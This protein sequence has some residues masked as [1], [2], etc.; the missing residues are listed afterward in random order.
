L[1]FTLALPFADLFWTSMLSIA[2]GI[3]LASAFSAIVV[4]GQE[5]LPG[6][7]GMVAGMFFGFSF[8][9]AALGAAALGEVADLTSITFVYRVCA[10]LPLLGLFA[11]F[12]P[13]VE[14]NGLQRLPREEIE[15][16]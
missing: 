10:F 5:L 15:A 12:L 11:M 4:Y 16:E 13:N 3:I 8:G 6:R 1:P 2:I 14:A 9:M 7:V